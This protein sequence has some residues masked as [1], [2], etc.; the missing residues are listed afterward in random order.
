M[1][2]LIV[3]PGASWS[4]A[5][6]ED[7]L[8]YGLE[9]LDVEVIRYRLDVRIERAASWLNAAWKRAKKSDPRLI[10]PTVGDVCY[11]AATDALAMALRHQVDV[12]VVMSAMFFHP[13]VVILMKRA[14][15][16]VAAL[17]TESPY[18]SER[19]ALLARL[20]DHCWT[21]DRASLPTFAAVGASCRYLPHGWHPV[22]HRPGPQPGDAAQPAHDVV[23]VGSAFPERVA[24]LEAVDWTGI[25]LGLYGHWEGLKRCSPLRPFVKGGT[26]PNT[27]TAALYRRAA[28][29]LNL[30]R[31]APGAE[32]LNPRAYEL[33]ACGVFH[34]SDARAEVREIFG[35]SVP[36]LDQP[37]DAAPL[38]HYWLAHPVERAAV[39]A[40][41]PACV[42]SASW[43][44]RAASVLEDCRALM[45]RSLSHA[46]VR[47]ER[48][49]RLHVDV[50]EHDRD[51]HLPEQVVT[52]YG[53]RKN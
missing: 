42:A 52:Q 1:K 17:F 31:Q 32:S 6:V 19:E 12:V 33:A 25:D 18:D 49:S 53:D 10:A 8:R 51:R 40:D 46:E 16:T 30:Y 7:G 50:R 39:A 44:S 36:I 2:I 5:D 22:Y 20:V 26:V 3:H 9:L 14:G 37:E 45:N 48:R 43:I 24:W 21:N 23:F 47:R 27:T 15:L 13:D 4:T 11:L 41:L 34:L 38:I 28:I 35:A 29:G